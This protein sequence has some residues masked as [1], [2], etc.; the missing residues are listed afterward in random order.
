[1]AHAHYE[2]GDYIIRQGEP[3]SSFYVIEKGEV[4]IVRTSPEKPEGEVLA[5]LG[6]GNFF[7]ESALLNSQPRT[8]SAR[9]RTTAEIVI[10]GRHVF[11]SISQSLAPLK[12]ALTAAI[13]RRSSNFWTQRPAALNALRTLQ[14]ADFIEPAPAPLLKPT[15]RLIDVMRVFAE[16]NADFFYVSSDGSR[17]EGIVTLTDLLRAQAGDT[18]ADTPAVSFMI[19][20]PAVITQSDT[21]L[22]AASAFRE[23][24]LKYLPVVA[25]LPSRRI[26]GF[27]RARKLM[28]SV[29][30]QISAAPAQ[31]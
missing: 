31:S 30:Q 25:D 14:L 8:A 18:N 12:M 2:P 26:V 22:V 3:P 16:N 13:T 19:K 17:L 15:D 27:I 29:M 9:A 24:S 1:M 7:G 4:E 28:A 23:H 10:M 6:A 5:V 20:D 21:A 11:T